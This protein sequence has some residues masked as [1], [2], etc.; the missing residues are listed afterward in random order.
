L[1]AAWIAAFA[2]FPT[3]ST[4]GM[5]QVS[6]LLLLGVAGFLSSASRRRDYLAGAF[7]ALTTIK[8]HVL[9]LF[10]IA[11]L[12]WMIAERR[13]RVAAGFC[14][15]LLPTLGILTLL[16]PQWLA[17]YRT[18][19]AEP[20]LY[21]NPPTLGGVLRLWA[22]NQSAWLQ[23]LPAVVAGLSLLAYLSIKRPSLDWRTAAGPVLL[24]SVPTAAYG[25]SFDQIVLLVPLL[26]VLRW[27]A[28]ERIRGARPRALVIG[29]LGALAIAMLVQAWRVR[30]EHFFFWGPLALAAIY[31]YAWLRRQ[32]ARDL[33]LSDTA[34]RPAADDPAP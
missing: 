25:W 27:V 12:W 5:G 32:P 26:E 24:A 16:W 7:L 14:A 22:P 11:L 8:P 9:Y 6:S 1:P 33:N 34:L 18:A 2:F 19:M 21:W 17:G 13:W 3:L 23:F 10:W 29:A 31:L 15:A 30:E 4:L 28:D 20:P